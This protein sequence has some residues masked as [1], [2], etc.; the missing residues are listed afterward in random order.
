MERLS[1]MILVRA[2]W[3]DEA[4]VWVATSDDVTGLVTEAASIEVLAAKLPGLIADLLESNGPISTLPEIPIH[5]IAEKSSRIPNP[6][7]A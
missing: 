6:Q 5:I 2:V 1:H 4:N 3:D 7:A